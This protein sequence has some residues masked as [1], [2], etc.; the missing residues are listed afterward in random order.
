MKINIEI[1]GSDFYSVKG[2]EDLSNYWFNV[3]VKSDVFL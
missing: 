3:K 2:K 1:L